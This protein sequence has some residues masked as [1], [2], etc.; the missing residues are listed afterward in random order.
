[1]A[2]CALDHM[3][4]YVEV[5]ELVWYEGTESGCFSVSLFAFLQGSV[6]LHRNNSSD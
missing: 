2:V 6:V 5:A 4:V 3:Y 1:M